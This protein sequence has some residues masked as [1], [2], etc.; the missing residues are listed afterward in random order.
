[1]IAKNASGQDSFEHKHISAILITPLGLD[2]RVNVRERERERERRISL[3]ECV[4]ER[5]VEKPSLLNQVKAFPLNYHL[6]F[7]CWNSETRDNRCSLRTL[8]HLNTDFERYR[9]NEQL[10]YL[11][12]DSAVVEIK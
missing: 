6:T 10:F 1:M 8:D 11:I 4:Y 2:K 9:I 5:Y 12:W 7:K 3:C